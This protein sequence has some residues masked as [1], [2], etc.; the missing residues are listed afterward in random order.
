MPFMN[1]GLVLGGGGIVGVAWEVGVMQGLSDG[2]IDLLG[3]AQPDAVIGTSAGSTVGALMATHTLD[4]MA[5]LA[6]SPD[7]AVVAMETVPLLDLEMMMECWAVWQ[8]L[9]DTKPET[10]ATVGAYALRTKTVSQDR[11]VSS[12]TDVFGTAWPSEK[13]RCTAVNASTGEFA[14][15]G[16]DSDVTLDRALA[17]SCSVPCIFPTITIQGQQYTDGG[18][19]SPTSIDL[20]TG[21]KR[22]LVLAPIG[23]WE[24]DSLDAP[25]ALAMKNE[26][27]VV[28][29][30]GGKV[31]TLMPDDQT[32]QATLLTPLGRMD[33]D[34]RPIA[35]THGRRQGQ[36][37]AGQITAWW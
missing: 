4:Q 16:H 29:A 37:L 8:A 25:A 6:Q 2:G 18:V 14:V 9:P 36:E 11:F 12:M 7:G 28:E 13:F 31:V 34:M 26:S 35:L 5:E 3:A 19:R 21:F 22:V 10:L 20:L 27:A 32:N 30:A 1:R 33:P 15:W 17:S 24:A 23:S